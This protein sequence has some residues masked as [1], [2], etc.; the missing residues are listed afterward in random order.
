MK[1]KAQRI[2]EA[3]AKVVRAAEKFVAQWTISFGWHDAAFELERAV[4]AL[5]K[6]RGGR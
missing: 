5:K 1:T 4:A 2:K 3:E 6:T